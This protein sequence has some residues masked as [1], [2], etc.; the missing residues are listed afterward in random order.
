VR[1]K[2]AFQAG[3]ACLVA[4]ATVFVGPAPA[5]A[6]PLRTF[7]SVLTPEGNPPTAA[8]RMVIDVLNGNTANGTPV[9]IWR[10]N[11]E[12]Q[13]TWE[14]HPLNEYYNGYRKYKFYNMKGNGCLDMAI[15]GPVGNLTRVQQWGCANVSNQKWIA[16]P[17]GAGDTAPWVELKSARNPNLCLDVKG[18]S[19]TDGARLQVYT[20]HGGWNQR[21]NIY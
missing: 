14:I 5:N 10:R 20:C 11:A 9:Q 13:Q 6:D 8:N 17:V 7:I 2:K 4:L 3:A 16:Y 19:Y 1:I 21:F 12:P 15:D 18:V